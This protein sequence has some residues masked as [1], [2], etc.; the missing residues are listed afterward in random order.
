MEHAFKNL[1]ISESSTRFDNHTVFYNTYFLSSF[2][3]CAWEHFYAK[4]KITAYLGVRGEAEPENM[5]L[6]LMA[7]R[8]RHAAGRGNGDTS[9]VNALTPDMQPYRPVLTNCIAGVLKQ[10]GHTLTLRLVTIIIVE[11][12]YIKQKSKIFMRKQ[13]TA[14]CYAGK[15]FSKYNSFTDDHIQI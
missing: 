15:Y 2:F 12:N 4:K 6:Y 8:G 11:Q 10:H 14:K 7:L 9:G 13:T 1:L 5:F 3:E